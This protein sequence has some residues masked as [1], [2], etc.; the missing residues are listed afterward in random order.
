MFYLLG[1]VVFG[2]IVGSI[3]A[4]LWPQA[5]GENRLQTIGIGCV[6]S[7]VGGILSSIV[8]GD[9]YRPAGFAM[10][11]IGTLVAMWIW[12]KANE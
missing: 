5:A 2:W 12:K 8:L 4:M 9:D 6:G 11:V 1:W 3:A 10:S 7:I